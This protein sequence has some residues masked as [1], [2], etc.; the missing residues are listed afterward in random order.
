MK[1][2]LTQT[3]VNSIKPDPKKPQWIT[4]STIQNL[5]LYV[6]TSGKKVWY[7]RYLLNEQEKTHK[8]GITNELSVAQ[9][10]DMANDFMSRLKRGENPQ[11]KQLPKITFG[12]FLTKEYE[13]WILLNH[14]SGKKTLNMLR[15]RFAFLLPR[16]LEEI[17]ENDIEKWRLERQKA[18]V[19]A[20]TINRCTASLRSAFSWAVKKGLMDSNPL[21][22]LEKLR[23]HDSDVKVRY[24]SEGE[25]KYLMAALDARERQLRLHRENHNQHLAEREY[26]LM[27]ELDGEFA[28]YLK[29]MILVALNTGIRQN[30][31]FSLEWG[32]IDFESQT[33]TLRAK[34]TKSKKTTMLPI[35]S[36]VVKTLTAWRKQS[37]DTSPGALIFPS[38]KGG[39]KFDN[40]KKAWAGLMEDA[41]IENFRWHDMRHDFASQLVMKGVDL[42][43]V[44]ELMGHAS[45]TMTLRYAHLAPKSKLRA[46]EVLTTL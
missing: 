45:L 34:I 11:K 23:E 20:A 42:N 28:D 15:S 43:T 18:G 7:V 3:F 4:D 37:S 40:C 5:R 19:K 21:S 35:N 29:P 13:E 17:H 39:G 44:R 25:R 41:G 10:R 31:L 6:G 33:M 32:D 36:V 2:R 8:L 12:E 38:P 27:P 26:E 24:L 22:G 1:T 9:A 30:N 16:P 14:G 46:A